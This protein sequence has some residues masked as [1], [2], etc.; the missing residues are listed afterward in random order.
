[1]TS[2][3]APPPTSR[4]VGRLARGFELH[5]ER[6][7][8]HRAG[9]LAP[10]PGAPSCTLLTPFGVSEVA[11]SDLNRA[12]I[13]RWPTAERMTSMMAPT[14]LGR[15]SGRLVAT[16]GSN[17]I[18]T[19][20]L[21]VITNLIEYDMDVAQA[22]RAPRVHFERKRLSV[23]GGFD[24]ACLLGGLADAFAQRQV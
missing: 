22:V 6:I 3:T 12:G 5:R 24:E 10:P 13:H 15:R 17:R 19:P 8:A 16:G 1:M 21:Q 4:S 18:R 2:V 20:V 7:P 14:A 9:Q 23:E 11:H